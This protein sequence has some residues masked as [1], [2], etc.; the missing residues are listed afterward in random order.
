MKDYDAMNEEELVKE[1][2]RILVE[3]NR[4]IALAKIKREIA[5]SM[6][7]EERYRIAGI[8]I[9]TPSWVGHV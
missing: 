6:V 7:M 5:V 3:E 9:S 4:V 2:D 8:L 1:A